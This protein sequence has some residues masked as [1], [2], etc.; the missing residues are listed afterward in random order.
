MILIRIVSNSCSSSSSS[1]SC[2]C[3]PIPFGI[4]H[5]QKLIIVRSICLI[6]WIE[7]TDFDLIDEFFFFHITCVSRWIVITCV[8]HDYGIDLEYRRHK[9]NTTRTREVGL[10]PMMS[11]IMNILTEVKKKREENNY[12]L[13]LV[14]INMEELLM[15]RDVIKFISNS[16]HLEYNSLRHGN[17][18][19]CLFLS[20]HY[21]SKHQAS[22]KH[23]YLSILFSLLSF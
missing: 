21:K 18:G 22:I 3:C 4:P 12:G 2:C 14:L 8:K 16:H 19:K 1:S 23:Y 15:N 7:R 17:V 11:I 13:I 5:D 20:F 9:Q 10:R 6:L